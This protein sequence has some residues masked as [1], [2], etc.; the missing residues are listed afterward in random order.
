MYNRIKNEDL[1]SCINDVLRIIMFDQ[2][3]DG[4][5]FSNGFLQYL[6]SNFE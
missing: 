6:D 4:I 5:L 1:L 3:S 2:L